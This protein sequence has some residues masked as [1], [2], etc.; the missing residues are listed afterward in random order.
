M[1]LMTLIQT[2]HDYSYDTYQ[3]ALPC[4][5]SPLPSDAVTHMTEMTLFQLSQN[6]Y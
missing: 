2:N 1:T 4:Q 3:S 6:Y 5:K